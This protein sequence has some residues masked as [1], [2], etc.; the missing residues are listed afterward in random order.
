MVQDAI[1]SWYLVDLMQIEST[2]SKH[3]EL[4]TRG[5]DDQDQKNRKNWESRNVGNRARKEVELYVLLDY[6]TRDIQKITGGSRKA[7]KR[8]CNILVLLRKEDMRKCSEG[9]IYSSRILDTEI[10]KRVFNQR[11]NKA[12]N[13]AETLYMAITKQQNSVVIHDIS[14]DEE[15][16][17]QDSR[18]PRIYTYNTHQ[19]IEYHPSPSKLILT[20]TS[21]PPL[22]TRPPKDTRKRLRDDS[23]NLPSKKPKKTPKIV[24]EIH[25]SI[26]KRAKKL[27]PTSALR[28][29]LTELDP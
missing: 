23:S 1:D 15:K 18:E 17:Y 26:I 6:L 8:G 13:E 27:D 11:D 5:E 21:S 7:K 9:R 2:C 22:E 28:K 12:T 25:S 20:H 16:L 4:K 29:A 10:T 19:R 14:S 3:Q 24:A